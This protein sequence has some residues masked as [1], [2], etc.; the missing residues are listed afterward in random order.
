MAVLS[1]APDDASP[2]KF[3]EEVR[4][5]IPIWRADKYGRFENAELNT[6][7]MDLALFDAAGDTETKAAILDMMGDDWDA[8]CATDD[9]LHKERVI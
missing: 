5:Q 3:S 1:M 6:V 4:E 2:K 9:A 7:E 8:L